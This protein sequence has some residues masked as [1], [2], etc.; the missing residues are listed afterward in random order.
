VHRGEWGDETVLEEV[1]PDRTR[2]A[3]RAE[4]LI[5]LLISNPGYGRTLREAH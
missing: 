4:G 3:E 5:E 1:F 2:A